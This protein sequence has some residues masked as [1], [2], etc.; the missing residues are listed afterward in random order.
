MNKVACYKVSKFG[1]Q[2][3]ID[4]KEWPFENIKYITTY[5][6]NLRGIYEADPMI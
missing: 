1:E 2:K 5:D 4:L 3:L 6:F